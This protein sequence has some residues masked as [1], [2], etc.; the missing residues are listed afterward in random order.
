MKQTGIKVFAPASLSNL[1][2]G[3]D[4]LGLALEAPGDEITAWFT[5]KKGL[6]L[7]AIHGEKGQ[8]P[9]DPAKNAAT[10]AAQ[11]M[12]DHLGEQDCG[13]AFELHKKMP[14]AS[15]LGSSAA[16]AVA[17]VMA[18]NELLKKP[19]EKRALL[20]FAMAGEYGVTGGWYT[21]NV[22]ASLLGGIVLIRDGKSLDIHRLPVPKGLYVTVLH[23]HVQITTKETRNILK[24]DLSLEAMVTQSGNLGGLIHGLY[25]SDFGLIGRS[26]RDVII[27]KQRAGIIPGFYAMQEAAFHEGALGCSIS[28]SGPAVFA[29]CDN[30]LSAENCG[31]KMSAIMY[32]L[33]Q[34]FTLYYS[35]INQ[36]GACKY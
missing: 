31:E 30:S 6:E 2:C 32:G 24:P 5:D 15:G 3:F 27:E 16:S 1:A 10:L 25:Q 35:R 19:L 33:K 8:L 18:I 26:L 14:F 20:P 13:V 28:G 9:R 17:G 22:A 21:D 4:I 23:P 36:E 34:E 11:A 7:V 12:L 29:L